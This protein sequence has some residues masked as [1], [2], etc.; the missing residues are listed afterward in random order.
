MKRLLC[1][2]G[3]TASGKTSLALKLS[4]FFPSI[5]VSADSRQ[6]YR[7]MDIVT[8][9]DHP[10]STTLYGIDLVGPDEECSVSGWYQ[11]VIP[12]IEE[13]WASDLLP[14]IVGG[15]GLYFRALTKGIE[16]M[17]I[18]PNQELR[19]SLSEFPVQDLQSKLGELD[20]KKLGSMNQSDRQNP[21]RLI[22]AIE[23]A[24]SEAKT[25]SVALQREVRP[26]LNSLIIGLRPFDQGKFTTT[27]RERVLSRLELGALQETQDL[28]SKYPQDLP[29]FSS[30]GY[31]HLIDH[32]SGKLTE[33]EL[34]NNWT[35]EELQYSKRQLTWFNKV[36]DLHWFDSQDANLLS[37]VASLVKDWY[38][39]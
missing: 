31:P 2:A 11:A 5:L 4:E 13:A 24:S 3:P 35:Q 34:I 9:K 7:E 39:K 33:D 32:L 12:A 36:E 38:S 18:P 26:S 15:T 27:V 19:D 1:I 22:R 30:L 25:P 10:E 29:S 16:T 37:G 6:V 23:V 17:S 8:G 28:L 21:R 14:I 20:S